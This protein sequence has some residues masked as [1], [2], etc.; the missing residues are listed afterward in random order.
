MPT[1]IPPT[2]R[3]IPP[4]DPS[5]SV[6]VLENLHLILFKYIYF[7]TETKFFPISRWL[8]PWPLPV[9]AWLDAGVHSPH[10]GSLH[11]PGKEEPSLLDSAPSPL[12]L[13]L[14][15]GVLSRLGSLSHL[16]SF[17]E[18]LHKRVSPASFSILHVVPS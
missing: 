11:T 2:V 1:P 10:V 9:P 7:F 18:V 8:S 15:M 5:P 4:S 3:A 14:V 16:S 6:R 13:F 17:S 12:G